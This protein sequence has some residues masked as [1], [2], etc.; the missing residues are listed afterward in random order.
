M[1]C[2]DVY[3]YP[4]KTWWLPLPGMLKVCLYSNL[5]E[6]NPHKVLLNRG[7]VI[8]KNWNGLMLPW[9]HNYSL[10]SSGA[11]RPQNGETAMYILITSSFISD[12]C[13][14]VSVSVK[15]VVNVVSDKNWTEDCLEQMIKICMA[16]GQ[17]VISCS[18]HAACVWCIQG[19]Y[20]V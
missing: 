7:F 19:Q 11:Q 16:T 6:H 13:C 18:S 1:G 2:V 3:V 15:N 14:L 17:L 5:P 20:K 9:Q 10:R 4:E 8:S 12:C